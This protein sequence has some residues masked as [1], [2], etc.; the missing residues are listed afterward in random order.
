MAAGRLSVRN[1]AHLRNQTAARLSRSEA[2][3]S[4]WRDDPKTGKNLRVWAS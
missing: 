3:I 4:H 2:I 1:H